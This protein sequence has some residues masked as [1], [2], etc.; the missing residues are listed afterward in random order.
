MSQQEL[1]VTT[2]CI[3][4]S[5]WLKRLTLFNNFP[6]EL[7]NLILWYLIQYEAKFEIIES[8]HKLNLGNMQSTFQFT[9]PK[10]SDTHIDG[11]L[12]DDNSCVKFKYPLIPKIKNIIKLKCFTK[13]MS[14]HKKHVF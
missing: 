6:K 3:A 4:I 13:K 12:L 7:N 5:Q 8:L 14:K 10:P 1:D 11:T 2:T 9:N